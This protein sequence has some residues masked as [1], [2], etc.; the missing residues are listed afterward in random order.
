MV[1]FHD[2]KIFILSHIFNHQIGG[3]VLYSFFFFF[4]NSSIL[5]NALII[6]Y[7]IFPNMKKNIF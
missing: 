5:Y 1:N 2:L 6:D 3:R 4:Q 7:I